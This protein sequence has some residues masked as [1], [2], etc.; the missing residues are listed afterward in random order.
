MTPAQLTA[1]QLA[2]ARRRAGI[3]APGEAS[4][5]S[6]SPPIADQAAPPPPASSRRSSLA[7]SSAIPQLHQADIDRRP[8]EKTD[9]RFWTWALRWMHRA[10]ADQA[11]APSVHY[12][13]SW[14]FAVRRAAARDPRGGVQRSHA[15][16]A[17][18][19]GMARSTAQR[20]ADFFAPILQRFH[21]MVRRF[22]PGG[23]WHWAY[24][25]N[26]YRPIAPP[27]EEAAPP[28]DDAR[29]WAPGPPPA[30]PWLEGALERLGDAVARPGDI[31]ELPPPAP[32]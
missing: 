5:P 17:A 14:L 31:G 6:S 12:L 9:S 24:R 13:Q 18:D 16:L 27:P 2:E 1:E 8:A 11:E 4:R 22:L 21:A 10:R 19:A 30:S 7:S 15:D 25:A 32:S 3:R 28:P 29:K 20:C 26:L 23:G